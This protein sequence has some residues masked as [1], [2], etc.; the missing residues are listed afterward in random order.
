MISRLQALSFVEKVELVQVRFTLCLRHQQSMWV[1]GGCK[2]YMYSYMASNESC[3][4]IIWII[5]KNHLSEVSLTQNQETMALWIVT[6][7]DLFYFIMCEDPHDHKFIEI[8]F[9]WGL[10][11]KW[12]HTTLECPWPHYMILKVQ[13]DG[14]WTLSFGLL[15]IHGHSSWLVCEVALNLFVNEDPTHDFPMYFC[16]AL[17]A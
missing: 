17:I 11:Y 4:M 14:L 9:G 6:T 1:Q 2:V 10:S 15:Q 5:F 12:L 8:A 3:F 13:W 7:I 16:R